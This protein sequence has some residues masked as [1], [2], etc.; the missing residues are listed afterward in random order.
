MY[1][2]GCWCQ[3]RV[4]GVENGWMGVQKGELVLKRGVGVEK[5]WLVSKT[6]G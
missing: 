1:K 6:D 5:G 4:V 3:K 2:T